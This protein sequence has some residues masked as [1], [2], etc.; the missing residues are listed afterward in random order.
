MGED[1]KQQLSRSCWKRSSGSDSGDFDDLDGIIYSDL[2]GDCSRWFEFA[3]FDS[4]EACRLLNSQRAVLKSFPVSALPYLYLC[5]CTV[6]KEEKAE[7]P[8]GGSADAK[9]APA[10]ADA[11]SQ[12]D[13][14]CIEKVKKFIRDRIISC[15]RDDQS[16]KLCDDLLADVRKNRIFSNDAELEGIPA[17]HRFLHGEA[18][19]Q[20]WLVPVLGAV[21]MLAWA[22]AWFRWACSADFRNVNLAWPALAAVLSAGT[23]VLV[24]K[25]VFRL[26]Y[27]PPR[28][29]GLLLAVGCF[30]LPLLQLV[31]KKDL[32]YLAWSV[33]S[34]LLWAAVLWAI[35]RCAGDLEKRKT[36]FSHNLWVR[37]ALIAGVLLL[38]LAP[39]YF[40]HHYPFPWGRRS[41]SHGDYDREMSVICKKRNYR[42]V[43]EAYVRAWR[44]SDDYAARQGALLEALERE[45]RKSASEDFDWKDLESRKD[46][47]AQ[48]DPVRS[49]RWCVDSLQPPWHRNLQKRFDKILKENGEADDYY[50]AFRKHDALKE[51]YGKF[52]GK[53]DEKIESGCYI[54]WLNRVLDD[55]IRDAAEGTRQIKFLHSMEISRKAKK[56]FP[57]LLDRTDLKEKRKVIEEK[58]KDVERKIVR[59]LE[60]AAKA[61]GEKWDRVLPEVIRAFEDRDYVVSSLYERGHKASGIAAHDER[62]LT[63]L[64]SWEPQT[65]DRLI[66]CAEHRRARGDGGKT[67]ANLEAASGMGSVE[68]MRLFSK[69]GKDTDPRVRKYLKILFDKGEAG[70]GEKLRLA[71]LSFGCEEW[72]TARQSYDAVSVNDLTLRDRHNR[73]VLFRRNNDGQHEFDELAAALRS[74]YRQS[75]SEDLARCCE[76]GRR[77]KRMDDLYGLLEK[78]ADTGCTAAN[79]KFIDCA[80]ELKKRVDPDLWRK[81]RPYFAQ[82]RNSRSRFVSLGRSVLPPVAFY[83]ECESAIK[84]KCANWDVLAEE[85][86][87]LALTDGQYARAVGFFRMI[88][89]VAEEKRLNEYARALWGNS[90]LSDEAIETY[91]KAIRRGGNYELAMWLGAKFDSGEISRLNDWTAAIYV[92]D[93]AI[94]STV[95][96]K[97]KAMAAD[98][99]V[100][101]LFGGKDVLDRKDVSGRGKYS[102]RADAGRCCNEYNGKKKFDCLKLAYEAGCFNALRHVADAYLYEE[103]DGIRPVIRKEFRDPDVLLKK[104]DDLLASGSLDGPEDNDK[105]V[106]LTRLRKRLQNKLEGSRYRR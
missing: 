66:K 103:D 33:F 92:W 12:N 45:A 42:P 25:S 24:C 90:D 5:I 39:L 9:A 55:V 58:T 1:W 52:I 63:A 80:H 60:E 64:E 94:Q 70:L 88:P 53:L 10:T 38:T 15:L 74:G 31:R 86:A 27:I 37:A 22:G 50:A 61:G 32:H 18:L 75:V 105:K 46:A 69:W 98:R 76:L 59:A 102:F 14:D 8:A 77:L 51:Q 82:N 16:E 101:I 96:P 83:A 71:R 72:E 54:S 7:Q 104:I 20:R 44:I 99:I 36:P 95:A 97:A 56:V 3:K 6:K 43:Y 100:G 35:K 13:G 57:D 78:L 68:A 30:S 89:A 67:L 87:L 49:D 26:V 85:A 34:L 93:L 84:A 91:V 21:L 65:A 11:G 19:R 4:E 28:W 47:F 2:G 23:F 62:Y 41:R 79:E 17:Y 81:L 106:F 73:A 40:F 48:R 29:L